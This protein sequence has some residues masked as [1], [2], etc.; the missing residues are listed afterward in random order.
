MSTS[1]KKAPNLGRIIKPKA[2]KPPTKHK[3]FTGA[4]VVRGPAT[5]ET[6]F[7]RYC[8]GK[9]DKTTFHTDANGKI[10]VEYVAP[11]VIRVLSYKRSFFADTIGE[12]SSMFMQ[13]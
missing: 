12:N 10:A 4:F 2:R 8:I 5:V 6:D 3:I 9:G 7:A 1:S 13:F 11:N